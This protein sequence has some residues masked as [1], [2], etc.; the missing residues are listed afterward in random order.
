MKYEIY[1]SNNIEKNYDNVF[2]CISLFNELL[3][4]KITDT[5]VF[6]KKHLF[7]EIIFFYKKNRN[8]PL[9]TKKLSISF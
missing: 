5:G 2:N 1:L 4:T 8:Y 7:L 3:M 9:T 6:Q